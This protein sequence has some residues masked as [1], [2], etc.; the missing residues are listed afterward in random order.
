[1]GKGAG[2][3][4][5]QYVPPMEAF[6]CETTGTLNGGCGSASKLEITS[7]ATGLLVKIGTM[8]LRGNSLVCPFAMMAVLNNI[9]AK[10]N[11]RPTDFICVFFM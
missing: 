6:V 3:V 4:N 8:G 5:V 7:M 1:M 10:I 11:D 2:E 9:A